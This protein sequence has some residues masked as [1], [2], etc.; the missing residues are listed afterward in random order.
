MITRRQSLALGA[1]TAAV[2]GL[3]RPALA[4]QRN[5][6][7]L[8]GTQVWSAYD[9]GSTGYVEASA[10]A[11]AL[12]RAYGTRVRL[13]PSGTSIGR[14]LPLKQRRATSRPR[15]STNTPCP[16]GGRRIFAR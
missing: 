3:G 13:Q 7:S 8:P 12:G 4:Q 1:G 11:D 15:A 5:L 16:T 9:V 6:P 2:A 10:I 14:V